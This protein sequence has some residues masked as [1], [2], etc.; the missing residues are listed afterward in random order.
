MYYYQHHIGDYRRD[1]SHLTI[2]EHGAYRQ[3]LDLYYISEKPLDANAL[4][5]VCARSSDEVKAV[6]Q[7]LCEFFT[8]KN[9]KY[10]HKRCEDEILRFHSKS[11][12]AKESANIRWNKNNNLQ[13]AN[14]LQTDSETN[15]N[16]MLTI[17]HKPLT[18]NHIIYT[19]EFE[20]FWIAYPKKTGKDIA[21][22]SWKKLRP[23]IDD[24]MFSLSWQKE[25][26]QWVEGFIPNPSTYLNQGRWKDEPSEQLIGDPF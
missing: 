26:K 3:L 18:N 8:L 4:R 19:P 2:L 24:V 21:F 22:K 1:T 10:Y 13:D 7:I 14:A 15:A 5:L 25:S 23:R 16:A 17:N 11:T 20:Q 9:G 6:E 12:K